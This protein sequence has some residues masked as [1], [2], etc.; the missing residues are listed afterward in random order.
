VSVGIKVTESVCVPAP[1]MVPAAGTYAN[2]PGT[3]A[4]AFNCAPLNAAPYVIATGADQEIVGVTL[5]PALT[6]RETVL[7]AEV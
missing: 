2:V 1:K 6:V 4:V 3:E 5:P 7:V